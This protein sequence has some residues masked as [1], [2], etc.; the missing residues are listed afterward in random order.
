MLY[1]EEDIIR[2]D[3]NLV[4]RFGSGI[5]CVFLVRMFRFLIYKRY[6]FCMMFR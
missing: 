1:D 5:M 4:R 6:A 2:Y 3:S